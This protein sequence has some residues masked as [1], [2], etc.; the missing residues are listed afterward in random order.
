MAGPP[1]PRRLSVLLAGSV[2]HSEGVGRR[3]DAAGIGPAAPAGVE[4]VDCRDLSWSQLE[5]EEVEVLGDPVWADGL[6][7]GAAPVLDVPPE[8]DLR[9]R[10][11]VFGCEVDDGGVLEGTLWGLRICGAVDV[12]AAD[13]RPGLRDDP[14][15]GVGLPQIGLGEV[16]VH[17]DL[18]DSWD[19]VGAAHE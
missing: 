17:L 7:D 4:G 1:A 10:F 19:D 9:W 12:D 2:L 13:R 8:N 3:V 11:A 16:R 15:A 5:V 6:W 14:V 18:V